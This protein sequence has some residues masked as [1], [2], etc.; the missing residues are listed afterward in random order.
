MKKK[1]WNILLLFQFV[2]LYVKQN[3]QKKTPIKYVTKK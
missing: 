1:Y 2:Y 3:R